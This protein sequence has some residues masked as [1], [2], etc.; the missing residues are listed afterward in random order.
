MQASPEIKAYLRTLGARIRL[1]R[2]LHGLTLSKLGKATGVTGSAVWSYEQ[3]RASPGV[4]WLFRL[5]D[6]FDA[7]ASWLV[8]GLGEPP[9]ATITNPAPTSTTTALPSDS[10]LW[11][12]I[13]ELQEKVR[14]L[15][16]A[17]REAEGKAAQKGRK[18]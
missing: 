13:K 16:K 18:R 12:T 7:P 1:I 8:T 3:G 17:A 6:K 4:P 5:V 9:T 11:G 15:E 10:E 14:R 2:E